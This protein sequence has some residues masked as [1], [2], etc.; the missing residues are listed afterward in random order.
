MVLV[1]LACIPALS[2]ATLASADPS[3]RVEGLS[4]DGQA[5]YFHIGDPLRAP[6]HFNASLANNKEKGVITSCDK[7][8]W[9]HVAHVENLYG[10]SCSLQ[11]THSTRQILICDDTAVGEFAIGK[12]LRGIDSTA[13]LVQFLADHCGGG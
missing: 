4:E 7:F 1:L 9:A 13:A 8:I 3:L 10:A 12:A 11:F 6:E 5:T 2:V